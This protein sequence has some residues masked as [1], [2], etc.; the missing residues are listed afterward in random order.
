[1]AQTTGHGR[2]QRG[3]A[4]GHPML[5]G[6]F[7]GR[8]PGPVPGAGGGAVSEQDASPF[9][10]REPKQKET[11]AAKEQL[12]AGTARSGPPAGLP[13]AAAKPAEPKEPKEEAKPRFDFYRSCRASKSRPTHRDTKRAGP[14]EVTYLQAGAFQKSSDADNLKA[15]LALAGLEAQIQTATLSD[16]SVWHRVRLGPYATAPE[17]DR[18]RAVL[19]ENKIEPSV[20]KLTSREP[21]SL[22]NGE[23][24][25]FLQTLRFVLSR[26]ARGGGW[27]CARA[28]CR[29]RTRNTSSSTRRRSRPTAKK[30]EVIEF[31]SYACPH[32]ADFEPALQDWLKRKPKDVDYKA[33]PMVFRDNWKPPA[34][35]YYTLETMGAAGQ[36]SRQGLSTPS[37]RKSKQLFDDQ[38][39]VKWAGQAGASTPTSSTRSTTPSAST[40][41]CNA[42]WRWA[43]P[44]A[45]SSRPRIAV[46]GKYYTGPSM[47]T[48]PAG[49]VDLPALLRR[50]G[51]AHR[52]GAQGCRRSGSRQAEGLSPATRMN[53]QRRRLGLLTAALLLPWQ[54]A[55][56]D[57]ME[58]VDYRVIPQQPLADP[59]RIEVVEFFYYGCR[60]CNEFE[61]YVRR[62]AA[63]Q[64]RRC[65]LPPAAGDPQHALD[66]AD[67]GVLRARGR[68]R[69]PTPAWAAVSRLSPRRAQSRRREPC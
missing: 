18:A 57:L 59:A 22:N 30:I 65:R 50:G 14:R 12:P 25:R 56:L 42:P 44:T 5:I 55:A 45:C 7:I 54:A 33:V 43:A 60:W 1:M 11:P 36:V 26:T 68:G 37:T 63:T 38:A 53:L 41:R 48:G 62:V 20:I 61:P 58:E 40:P 66:R 3:G 13:Q 51:P 49:G 52:H 28:A 23:S 24:M 46:N 6:V 19:R 64:A 39:I 8:A 32:C 16:N 47:V 35:L 9:A 69:A 31:F 67:Q 2:L 10:A 29:S 27:R 4:A 15:R 21:K 17:L 34:K